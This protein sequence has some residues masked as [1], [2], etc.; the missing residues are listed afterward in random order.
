MTM[1]MFSLLMTFLTTRN[2]NTRRFHSI[3]NTF[4][5]FLLIRGSPQ[6][7]LILVVKIKI[8]CQSSSE[9]FKFGLLFRIITED[10]NTN[11]GINVS[12]REDRSVRRLFDA[13]RDRTRRMG[14]EFGTSSR[15]YIHVLFLFVY[16]Y[17]KLCVLFLCVSVLVF[18]ILEFDR[19][20]P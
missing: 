10:K 6:K 14:R 8:K 18:F 12:A 16:Y 4:R 20:A 19:R 3:L 2:N 15:V 5:F 11:H 13:T 7:T 1:M 9:I 17:A